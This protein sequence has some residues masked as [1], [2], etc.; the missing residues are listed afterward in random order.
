M[1]T[2]SRQLHN[3]FV[4]HPENGHRPYILRTPSLTF[5]GGV[6]LALKIWLLITF[7]LYPLEASLSTIT[8]GRMV[9]LTNAS[10]AENGLSALSTNSLLE[11]AAEAKARDILK[12]DYFA[13]VSPEGKEPWDF[14]TEAGYKYIYAGEN[15]AIGFTTAEGAHEALMNSPTHREN[16]LSENFTEIGIATM[17]GDYKGT[18]TTVCVEMFGSRV[19]SLDKIIKKD[20]EEKIE[21]SSPPSKKEI[22]P[23]PAPPK[24][25]VINTPKSGDYVSMLHQTI[26]GTAKADSTIFVFA[27][28]NKIGE[29]KVNKKG[30]FKGN[31]YTFCQNLREGTHSI[32]AYVIDKNGNK[33][34]FSKG[35][36]INLDLSPPEIDLESSYILPL[37]S[38]LSDKFYLSL[39][40]TGDPSKVTAFFGERLQTLKSSSEQENIYESIFTFPPRELSEPDKI[41]IKAIDEAGNQEEE[42]F[43]LATP[44][45]ILATDKET[46]SYLAALSLKNKF[47][48][49]AFSLV[50]IFSGL[51]FINIFIRIRHQHFPT[52]LKVI[53]FLMFVGL[54]LIV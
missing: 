1:R 51:L 11:K 2:F 48:R 7:A 52:I 27:D 34:N 31:L 43:A 40:I 9:Q 54:L 53:L 33:S 28:N 44:T 25:P 24:A 30:Y 15:L 17:T 23:P 37:L 6:V 8:A 47:T 13:H 36:T 19:E 4:P 12:K 26:S 3:T 35:I 32:K 50:L 20:S 5:L 42:V 29:I 21:I 49:F 16:I 14:I 18:E 38:P 10:R 41:T 22:P 39:Q 46:R 45:F